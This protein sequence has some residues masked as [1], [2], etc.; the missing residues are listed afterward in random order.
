MDL[1]C[2]LSLSLS[3]SPSEKSV[4]PLAA[5]ETGPLLLVLPN[6]GIIADDN[7]SYDAWFLWRPE[8]IDCSIFARLKTDGLQVAEDDLGECTHQLTHYMS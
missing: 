6:R 1:C 8:A 3:R 7:L 5:Y 4:S 2:H